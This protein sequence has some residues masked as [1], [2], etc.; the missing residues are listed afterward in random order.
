M[1]FPV[2][3]VQNLADT[4]AI[5]NI[6]AAANELNCMQASRLYNY[7]NDPQWKFKLAADPLMF[8]YP[9][10]KLGEAPF[11]LEGRDERAELLSYSFWVSVLEED[12]FYNCITG[13]DAQGM[14][15]RGYWHVFNDMIAHLPTWKLGNKITT[16]A[17]A[18][19]KL[20][21]HR[22]ALFSLYFSPDDVAFIMATIPC[23]T[24][25]AK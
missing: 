11:S 16:D 21:E 2:N 18:V 22:E 5:K 19:A 3:Y 14:I 20:K 15:K 7:S 6:Y 17:D 25:L 9:W 8:F 4:Y 10:G 24:T 13:T 23:T 12:G 1:L